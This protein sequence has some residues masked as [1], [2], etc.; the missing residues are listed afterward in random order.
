MKKKSTSQSAFFNLAG[1]NRPVRSAG[2]RLSGAARHGE[3]VQT[4]H[5]VIAAEV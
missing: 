5:R 2:W 3:S 1:L 4:E